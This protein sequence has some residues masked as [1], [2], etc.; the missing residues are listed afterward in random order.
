MNKALTVALVL[1]TL[2]VP[3]V[4][5]DL[6]WN[7]DGGPNDLSATGNSGT[8]N[9]A[10]QLGALGVGWQTGTLSS[11]GGYW[12][13]GKNGTI[14]LSFSGQQ[15]V[16][17][18][19]RIVQWC[20]PGIYEGNLSVL[21]G[22]TVLGSTPGLL[23][24]ANE[25]P[26]PFGRWMESVWTVSPGRSVMDSITIGAPEKGAI[27]KGVELELAVVPESSGAVAGAVACAIVV[28][29]C[30]RHKGHRS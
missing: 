27:V 4:C 22:A 19:L 10:I 1:F 20:D 15:P 14:Q 7:F 24:V 2:I 13:L 23:P 29:T 21:V 16:A 3:T 28:Y 11:S 5:G 8:G 18:I 17:A 12:D 26:S 6:I 25:P 9:A 30:W